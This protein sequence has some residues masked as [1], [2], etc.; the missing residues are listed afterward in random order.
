MLG[1]A[2]FTHSLAHWLARWRG[3][4]AWGTGSR[5]TERGS[6]NGLKGV[7][8]RGAEERRE[9]LTGGEMRVCNGIEREN[10]G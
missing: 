2:C 8:G 10:V 3:E 7:E 9:H 6:G 5:G 4:G 1:L